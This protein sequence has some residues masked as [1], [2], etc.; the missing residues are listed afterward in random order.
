MSKYDITKSW[1]NSDKFV[2]RAFAIWGYMLAAVLM[3]YV[4][5]FAVAIVITLIGTIVGLFL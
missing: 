2:K 4:A 1:L 5:M 3:F